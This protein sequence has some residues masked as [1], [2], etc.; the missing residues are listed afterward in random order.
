M[1]DAKIAK[2]LETHGKQGKTDAASFPLRHIYIGEGVLDPHSLREKHFPDANA[3]AIISDEDTHSAAG[4]DVEKALHKEHCDVIS[5]LL[6]RNVK[7]SEHEAR[8]IALLTKEAEILIAVGSGTINDLVKYASFLAGKPY[9]I[10]GT[11]PSMNGYASANAS[12]IDQDGFKTTRPAHLPEAIYLDTKILAKAPKRLIQSGFGDSIC[13]P[14][15]QVDWLLSNFLR[16]TPFNPFPFDLLKGIEPELLNN[17]SNL[18]LE[19]TAAVD[20]LGR[21]LILSGI[22]MYA[23]GGSYP[24]SQG[25]HMI[26][27]TMEMLHDGEFPISYHGEQIGVTTLVMAR[28]QE[29][30]LKSPPVI[31]PTYYDEAM[32]KA[33][34]GERL[35]EACIEELKAKQIDKAKA[36]EM[37][38]RI[39]AVWESFKDRVAPMRMKSYDIENHLKA[40]GAPTTPAEI[41]WPAHMFK[42]AVEMAYL[43]RNRF[44]FLDLAAQGNIWNNI[45]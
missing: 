6:S 12:I 31:S 11:A 8:E 29:E 44:T 16:D 1:I 41:N 10:V 30:I 5:H 9:I 24:A 25:E 21:T 39:E 17:A 35:G 13:R 38:A 14:T 34:F 22:G 43:T 2:L 32:I 15:A 4:M 27:H 40:C 26:A 7:P 19:D 20:V 23:A 45:L 33:T 37:N 3:V 42:E 36:A 18:T 28:I